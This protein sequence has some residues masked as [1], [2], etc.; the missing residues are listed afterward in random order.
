MKS[1]G[2]PDKKT[3]TY[4]IFKLTENVIKYIIISY[5]YLKYWANK[6]DLANREEGN[7]EKNSNLQLAL[8]MII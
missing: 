8:H 3:A 1:F 5:K 7:T 2:S 6:I 4:R